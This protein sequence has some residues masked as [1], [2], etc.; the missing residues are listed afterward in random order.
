M[1]STKYLKNNCMFLFNKI[2]NN[3]YYK[4]YYKFI[5]RNNNKFLHFTIT[6]FIWNYIKSRFAHNLV[7]H[8]SPKLLLGYG[9]L[10]RRVN[11]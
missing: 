6:N 2:N 1:N 8:K 10:K 9:Q 5:R 3:I 4:I 7:F 11:V